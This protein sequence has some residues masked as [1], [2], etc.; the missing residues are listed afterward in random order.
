MYVN[1][2]QYM[3]SIGYNYYHLLLVVCILSSVVHILFALVYTLQ[4]PPAQPPSPL[5]PS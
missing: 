1:I 4:A 2:S 5:L 3:Q